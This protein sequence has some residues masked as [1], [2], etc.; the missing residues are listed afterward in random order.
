MSPE[1][2]STLLFN[3]CLLGYCFG[4][5]RHHLTLQGAVKPRIALADAAWCGAD[6]RAPLSAVESRMPAVMRSACRPDT[7]RDPGYDVGP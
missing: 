6:T 3:G 1:V 4:R 2:S 5:G 7:E